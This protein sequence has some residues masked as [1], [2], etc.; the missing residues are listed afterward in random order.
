MQVYHFPKGI[1]CTDLRTLPPI[2][3]NHRQSPPNHLRILSPITFQSPRQLEFFRHRR[4]GNLVIRWLFWFTA[5]AK[6]ESV[7]FFYF[8]ALGHWPVPENKSETDLNAN[9]CE[10]IKYVDERPRD[11]G[12]KSSRDQ[13][14]DWGPRDQET[15]RPR[16]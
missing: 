9:S 5:K 1:A 8:P 12:I 16:T 15:K 4:A 11:P 7:N 2:T 6:N 14:T 3:L 13:A 10:H